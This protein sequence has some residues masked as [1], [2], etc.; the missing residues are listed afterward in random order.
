MRTKLIA[1]ITFFI[2]FSAIAQQSNTFPASGNVGIGTT[3]PLGILNN[4]PGNTLH[5]KGELVMENP[6]AG[7]QQSN[8]T[9]I[10][11]SSMQTDDN[12]NRYMG[13]LVS[14]VV[15][16]GAGLKATGILVTD[17]AYI[18]AN[19]NKGELI[20]TKLAAIG[21]TNTTSGY[22][23]A[24]KGSIG[25]N[26]I[27]VLDVSG[28]ADYVFNKDYHLPSLTQVEN[29]ININR[30]LPDVPSENEVKKNGID[31]VQNQVKLLQKIEELTLYLIEQEKRICV[32]EGK[33]S[34]K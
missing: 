18:N 3:T 34:E 15:R 16:R 1:I 26:R 24:V 22:T 33:L 4:Y 13:L 12:S 7:T 31:L 14:P 25:C 27:K 20:V 2:S 29:F 30:H 32:L 5:I 17:G 9:I 11:V 23:L 28:W 10:N 8:Q 21:T 6:Q 19:P